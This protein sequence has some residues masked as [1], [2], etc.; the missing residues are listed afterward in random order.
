MNKYKTIKVTKDFAEYLEKRK[1]DLEKY[2]E[3]PKNKHIL[4]VLKAKDSKFRLSLFET[5]KLIEEV[6]GIKRGKVWKI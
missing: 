4:E 6:E 2:I 5:K 1:K 3:Q